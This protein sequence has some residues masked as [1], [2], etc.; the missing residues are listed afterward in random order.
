I[1]EGHM[2]RH[3][4]RTRSLYEH[5]RQSVIKALHDNFGEHVT[6]LGDNAGI[7]VLIRLRSQLSDEEIVARARDEE[8]GIVS[9]K[10][11]YSGS[12]PQGEFLLNYGGLKEELIAEGI[13]RL[14]RVARSA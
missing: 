4:R 1:N 5:R 11:F 2:E 9:T 12:S 8:V 14:A 7:N 3:V 10:A 13:A 6:I